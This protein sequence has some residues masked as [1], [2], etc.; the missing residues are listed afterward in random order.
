M[1][2]ID[3]NLR[4]LRETAVYLRTNCN[5]RA[6]PT[7]FQTYDEAWDE[8]RQNIDHLKFKLGPERYS[9]L[10]KMLERAKAHYDAAEAEAV[11]D[12]RIDPGEPG[13]ENSKLGS[14]LMQDIGLIVD[15]KQPAVYPKALSSW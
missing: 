2:L 5:A 12:A 4:E 3:Q 13:F 6:Y 1:I 8:L 14:W 15:G 7:E 9:K 10:L 11:G